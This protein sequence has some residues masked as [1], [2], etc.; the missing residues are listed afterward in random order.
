MD[1]HLFF[2]FFFRN[3]FL[4]PS[5]A[6]GTSKKLVKVGFFC[7]FTSTTEI[8]PY[9]L[10]YFELQWQT[11]MPNIC[12]R[13]SEVFYIYWA[14]TEFSFLSHKGSPSVVFLFFTSISFCSQ[15]PYPLH[16]LGMFFYQLFSHWSKDGNKSFPLLINILSTM[17]QSNFLCLSLPWW[18]F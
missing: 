4:F 3:R 9:L 7:F 18:I 12:S 6:V 10:F 13:A 14:V 17:P 11:K 15:S 1:Y 5:A 2:F 8:S 16:L